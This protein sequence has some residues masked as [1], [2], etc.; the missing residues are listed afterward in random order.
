MVRDHVMGGGAVVNYATLHD[1]LWRVVTVLRNAVLIANDGYIST[2]FAKT[3]GTLIETSFNGFK[4]ALNL[5][6]VTNWHY[7]FI[8]GKT[9]S[10]T[11]RIIRQNSFCVDMESTVASTSVILSCSLNMSSSTGLI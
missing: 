8:L 7:S 1:V 3:K 11:R 2:G 4:L 9:P 10:G 6:F 5:Y